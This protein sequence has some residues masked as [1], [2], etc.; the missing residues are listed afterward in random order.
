[1]PCRKGRSKG[2]RPGMSSGSKES[3]DASNDLSDSSSGRPSGSK[4]Q[5]RGAGHDSMEKSKFHSQK[6][7]QLWVRSANNFYGAFYGHFL[8]VIIH[9]MPLR[10]PMPN[11]SPGIFRACFM[12]VVHTWTTLPSTVCPGSDVRAPAR[13]CELSLQSIFSAGAANKRCITGG[14]SIPLLRQAISIVQCL[15]IHL[16]LRLCSSRCGLPE[17]LDRGFSARRPQTSKTR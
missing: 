2:M 9:E 3:S 1:M 10:V 14:C 13:M 17:A 7:S 6:G 4:L 8:L 11:F 5:K 15:G 12:C 16:P